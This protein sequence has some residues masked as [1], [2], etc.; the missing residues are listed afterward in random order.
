VTSGQIPTLFW[1]DW[2]LAPGPDALALLLAALYLIGARRARGWSPWRTVWFLSGV[3][4]GLVAVQS[5]IDAYDDVLLSDHMVQHLLL[6]ELAP[7]LLL[8][9][10]P[11]TL[12]LRTAAPARRPTLAR[13]VRVLRRVLHP[14]TCIAVLWVVVA[15]THLPAFYDATLRHPLLHDTEHAL[16]LTAGLLMWWPVL[17]EDPVPSHQL[18]GVLRLLY[19]TL[20][21]LPMTILGAYLDRDTTLLYA[22]YAAPAH[23]LGISAVADQQQAGAIMWVLGSSLMVVCGIWQAMAAMIAEERR[24][25][26]RERRA[27]ARLAD[28]AVPRA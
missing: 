10:R 2:Q 25:Q 5:G 9:G 21:M 17:D 18:N 28:E 15:G 1:R 16:F 7:L 8:A 3:V 22:P 24:M 26:S 19:M 14:L 13:R 6:L 11:L 20:A 12:I 23:A 27:D 4:C